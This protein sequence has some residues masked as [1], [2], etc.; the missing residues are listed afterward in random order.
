MD[1]YK[2]LQENFS[3][4][5]REDYRKCNLSNTTK[6]I[7]CDVGLPNQPLNFLQFNIEEIE[8][9]KFNEEHI[10]IGNDFGTNICI[11]SKEEI[12]SIDSENEYP[13]RFINKNLETFI[14]FII[15]FL[16]YE[17]K[18]NNADDDE[19]MQVIQEIKKEFN[20]I[21]IQALSNEENWW[22]IIL[23]Q[24]ELGLM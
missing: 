8:N 5:T 19:I 15:T 11:N 21:D 3:L 12:V 4:N 20:I 1:I 23:E 24:I 16:S 18:I 7:L 17:D 2:Y 14:E 13:M 9:I 22:S 6:K 10:I